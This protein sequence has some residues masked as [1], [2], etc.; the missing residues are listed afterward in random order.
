[1]DQPIDKDFVSLKAPQPEPSSDEAMPVWKHLE[2]LRAVLIKSLMAIVTGF[3]VA[4]YFN[5]EIVKFLE[6]PILS[7]LPMGEKHLYFTGITDKFMAYLKV[8]FYSSIILCSPFLL[9]QVWGFVAPALKENERKLALPFIFA[10]TFAF[11]LGAL[12]AYHWVIPTGYRFLIEFG[13]IT[14]KPLINISD[15]FSLT[16]QLLIGMGLLFE[17]PVVATILAK[18]GVIE[19]DWLVRYRPQAYLGLSVLAAVLTPTPDAFTLVMVLIPL[20]LLYEI[21]IQ[22]VRWLVPSKDK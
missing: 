16:L 17:L 13:G 14:E 4:Y 7:V 19:L 3:F 11:L 6:T 5:A 22:L 2:E 9:S 21:S 1:M 8:S 10:G 15:Y 12:F 18:L 20:I